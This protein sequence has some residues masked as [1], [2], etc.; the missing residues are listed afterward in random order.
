MSSQISTP[1]V[2][3]ADVGG[4]EQQVGAERRPL[5][6]DGDLQAGDAATGG[7]LAPL[8]ELAVVRQVDLR[9]DAE[10]PAA[11]DHHGGVEQPGLVPQRRADD[12][13][14]QQV[15]A[16]LGRSPS[17]P[18]CTASSTRV[19][20]EQVVDGVAGQG[21]LGEH[22]DR[23]AGSDSRRLTVDHALARCA[24]GRRCRRRRCRRRPGRTRGRTATRTACRHPTG[25]RSAITSST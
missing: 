3:P 14:R 22:R 24:A 12:D 8:V 18:S 15:G 19:L 25:A 17:R 7:E 21:Q 23:D 11:V 9:H 10:H 1:T 20:A 16:G 6:G 2:S 5:P 4:L 13:H